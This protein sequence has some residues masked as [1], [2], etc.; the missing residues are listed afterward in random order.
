MKL[1]TSKTSVELEADNV[2]R[3][4]LSQ[5][6]KDDLS[7]KALEADVVRYFIADG[8]LVVSGLEAGAVVSVYTVDGT[9][10]V[11]RSAGTDGKVSL[12]LPKSQNGIFVVKANNQTFKIIVK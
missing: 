12:A 4:Y 6:E 5:G 2:D 10:L 1:T 3:I 9:L 8:Q 11:S 7:V